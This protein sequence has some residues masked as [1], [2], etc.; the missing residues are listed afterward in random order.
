MFS[1]WN[2]DVQDWWGPSKMVK[3]KAIPKSKS[4]AKPK[5]KSKAKPKSKSKAK[6]KRR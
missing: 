6:P 5:S 4:K 2:Q 3:G 1:L